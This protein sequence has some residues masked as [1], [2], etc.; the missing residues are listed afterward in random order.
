MKFEVNRPANCSVRT[1][2]TAMMV[3]C[4]QKYLRFS[5]LTAGDLAL[6]FAP[7]V[8]IHAWHAV[9]IHGEVK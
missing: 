3:Q 1:T 2:E 4:L 7:V 9:D 5:P 6:G 8:V